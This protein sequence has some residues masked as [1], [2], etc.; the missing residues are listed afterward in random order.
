MNG[1][2]GLIALIDM[3]ACYPNIFVRKN[4]SRFEFTGFQSG[5]T[6]KVRHLKGS[7]L[8]KEI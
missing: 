7:K 8:W 3:L 1:R 2:N 6:F 4:I 5:L